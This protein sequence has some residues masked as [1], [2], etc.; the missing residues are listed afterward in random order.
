VPPTGFR[1]AHFINDRWIR[2]GDWYPDR[3]TR[4]WQRGRADWGEQA[5]ARTLT[6][7]TVRPAI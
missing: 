2:H 5:S 4:L 6:V 3:Q 1:A 7:L